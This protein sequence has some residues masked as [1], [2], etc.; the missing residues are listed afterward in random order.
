[1]LEHIGLAGL[2]PVAAIEDS[3]LGVQTA[4]AV[5]DGG[6][7]VM[8]ITLRTPAGLT[9]IKTITEAFPEMIVGAGTVLNIEQAADS[10]AAGARFIVS[11]G[12]NS[13]LAKWCLERKI[14]YTPGC[15]T[16]TEIETAQKDGFDILKFFP[17]N[18]YDGIK[19]CKALAGPYGNIKFIPTGGV[20]QDNLGEFADKSFIHA[21]GGGWL[22]AAGDIKAENFAGI[23]E[24]VRNSIDILLGFK[25]VHVGINTED[26]KASASTADLFHEAFHF[27][28]RDGAISRFASNEIEVN[29]FMGIGKHG[30]LAIK[31]NNIFRAVHYLKKRGFEVDWDT[32]KLIGEKIIAVYLEQE[33]GGFGIHLLDL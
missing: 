29:K 18:V 14:T 25:M 15:V 1:M 26:D 10:A 17:A 16:P 19:S 3:G 23:A 31:T 5:L 9:S 32:K 11:P 8:E 30:H 22:C 24:T 13:E 20:N 2:V 7:D 33:F 4:K 28:L 12:Y 27:D 6:L 21:V